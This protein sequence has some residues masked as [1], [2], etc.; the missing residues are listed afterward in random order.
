MLV[1]DEVERTRTAMSNESSS[2]LL[3]LCGLGAVVCGLIML[4]SFLLISVM[5]MSI[6]GIASLVLRSIVDP[7]PEPSEFEVRAQAAPRPSARDLRAQARAVD[8]DAAV[9]QKGGD[10]SVRTAAPEPPAAPLPAPPSAPQEP[11]RRPRRRS[12]EDEDGIM[13]SFLDEG[14]DASPLGF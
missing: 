13:G 9:A 3:S 5:R 14:N 4:G 6:F 11:A 1:M 12:D 10:P 2:V 7:K 8:F